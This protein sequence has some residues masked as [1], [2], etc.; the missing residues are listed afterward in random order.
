MRQY[1]RPL[2]MW[3]GLIVAISLIFIMLPALS[4]QAAELKLPSGLKRIEAQAFY[5]DTS[6]DAVTV[7]EGT[8]VIGSKAFARSSVRTVSL[9]ASLYSI[10][11]DAFDG[12][13]NLTVNAQEGTYAY[14]WAVKKELIKIN[15]GAAG[16]ETKVI[17]SDTLR[18]GADLMV[19]IIGPADTIQHSV[20]IVNEQTG[21]YQSA[22]LNKARENV[23]FSGYNFDSGSTYRLTIRAAPIA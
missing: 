8:E 6:L 21:E 17:A 20:Y 16:E 13:E 18:A 19:Q 14:T 5:G 4:A 23:T 2:F 9:P 15:G 11:D 10:A 7:Q 12:C 1:R 22:Q 3:L